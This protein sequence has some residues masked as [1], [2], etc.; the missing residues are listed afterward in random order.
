[1]MLSNS[2]YLEEQQASW[3]VKSKSF[4]RDCERLARKPRAQHIE[5]RN[6]VCLDL[7]NVTYRLATI[8]S[9]VDRLAVF[10]DLPGEH[11]IRSER[12][13]RLTKR[14]NSCKQ[15]YIPNPVKRLLESTII[16]HSQLL[17]LGRDGLF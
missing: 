16:N 5:C 17:K 12:T 9:F 3:I 14:T 11:T 13:H 8:V 4:A 2:A 10:V 6:I 1:M 7:G 15:I